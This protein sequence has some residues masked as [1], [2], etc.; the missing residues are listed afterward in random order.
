MVVNSNKCMYCKYEWERMVQEN[1]LKKLTVAELNKYLCHHKL[2]TNGK[3]DDKVRL[4][5]LHVAKLQ[6][7][8]ETAVEPTSDEDEE[9]HDNDDE[10]YESS[11]S[12][13]DE[14]IIEIAGSESSSSDDDD[15]TLPIANVNISRSG[16]KILQNR[17]YSDYV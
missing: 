14:V 11:N 13:S 2:D 8:K 1:S 10:D 6:F 17:R 9:D 12:S 7:E 5:K 3:K 15:M 4:V 16:R